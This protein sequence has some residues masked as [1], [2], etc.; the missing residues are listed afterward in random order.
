MAYKEQM[1][2][3]GRGGPEEGVVG[4]E[5]SADD[6][7]LPTEKPLGVEVEVPPEPEFSDEDKQLHRFLHA[8]KATRGDKTKAAMM[9]GPVKPDAPKYLPVMASMVGERLYKK[10]ME[11][12]MLVSSDLIRGKVD[13]SLDRA[14]LL[15]LLSKQAMGIVPSR[16]TEIY[17]RTKQGQIVAAEIRTEYNQLEAMQEIAKILR[18]HGEGEPKANVQVGLLLGQAA[19]GKLR[20]S[21]AT[22]IIDAHTRLLAEGKR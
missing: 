7:H 13:P 10:A 14:S 3:F 12:G 9:A 16:R 20:E 19:Q 22:E 4:I 1:F 11:R 18:L 8:L 6:A 21:A 2:E 5:V 15:D 17:K